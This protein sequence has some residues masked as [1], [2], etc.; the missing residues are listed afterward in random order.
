MSGVLDIVIGDNYSHNM[1]IDLLGR[2]T[3]IGQNYI[4]SE[5]TWSYSAINR[6]VVPCKILKISKK[7]LD[8][9]ASKYP[10]LSKR[11]NDVIDLN[12]M[13]GLT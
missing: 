10:E 4:L 6:S 3:V 2:G 11:I 12:I 13:N 9:F 1:T 8:N 5:E 7:M